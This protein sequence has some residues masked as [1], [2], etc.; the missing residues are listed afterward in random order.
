VCIGKKRREST[1][2]NVLAKAVL[3]AREAIPINQDCHPFP[4]ELSAFVIEAA[5]MKAGEVLIC[6]CGGHIVVE[7]LLKLSDEVAFNDGSKGLWYS[8]GPCAKDA[9]LRCGLHSSCLVV[10]PGGR[11]AC[12]GGLCPRY[13]EG[14]RKDGVAMPEYNGYGSILRKWSYWHIA[15][16]RDKTNS[17]MAACLLAPSVI[18][19]ASE[20][21][22]TGRLTAWQ[23]DA[24]LALNRKMRE[25]ALTER[26]EAHEKAAFEEGVLDSVFGTMPDMEQ[27]AKLAETIANSH[28]FDIFRR[29]D[30]NTGIIPPYRN[31]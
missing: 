18:R 13:G 31:L 3:I 1:A 4:H 10:A 8:L 20:L 12:C 2:E 11:T 19:I 30:A 29:I 7:V 24:L 27:R 25:I 6:P 17:Y 22:K 16:N 23:S 15:R 21:L 9:K 26:T 5:K 14:H 28:S